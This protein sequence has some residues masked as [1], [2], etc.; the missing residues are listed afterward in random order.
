MN[1]IITINNNQLMVKEYEGQRVVTLWDVARLHNTDATHIRKNFENNIKYLIENED[2]YLI[3]KKSDFAQKIILS[4]E[5]KYHSINAAKNIPIFT[6]SGYLM[7]TKP[8]HDELSWQ[9][10]RQ[11]VKGYFKL[12]GQQVRKTTIRTTRLKTRSRFI[13]A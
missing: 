1:E 6:E 10:Q 7:I 4:K 12:D 13:K 9:V 3:D 11:L 8:L 2:Y 5:V